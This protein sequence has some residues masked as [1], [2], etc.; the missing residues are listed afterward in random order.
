MLCPLTSFRS[1][2]TACGISFLL[3]RLL[4]RIINN[5]PKNSVSKEPLLALLCTDRLTKVLIEPRGASAAFAVIDFSFGT[6]ERQI[7]TFPILPFCKL[8][9]NLLIALFVFNY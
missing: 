9:P 8:L 7:Q 1:D 6:S 2:A 3:C 4:D 5:L